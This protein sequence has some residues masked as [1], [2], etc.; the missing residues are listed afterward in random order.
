MWDRI[1]A[2][3][4]AVFRNTLPTA[5]AIAL[6][7]RL[8]WPLA[9]PPSQMS[10]STGAFT[11]P[12]SNALAARY[13]VEARRG[14]GQRTHSI[15][16][17][18]RLIYPAYHSLAW[19]AYETMGVRRLSTVVLAAL[20]GTATIAF[21]ALAV[22]RGPGD[23]AAIVVAVIGATNSWLVPNSRMFTPEGIA[24]FLLAIACF[25]AMSRR[26]MGWLA[27]GAIAAAAGTL[28]EISR[29]H[30]S[31]CALDLSP[32]TRRLEGCR[33][34]V[35]RSACSGFGMERRDLLSSPRRDHRMDWTKFRRRRGSF[36]PRIP[37][38]SRLADAVQSAQRF[39]DA[40]SHAD[41][42]AG[43]CLVCRAHAWL[44]RHVSAPDR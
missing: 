31:S 4:P 36:S 24:L 26:R 38:Q 10:W 33:E 9:D 39:L 41:R 42:V 27:A 6:L 12:P 19:I 18:E 37:F 23:Y 20:L 34:R 5:I 16:V 22:R 28:R 43:R 15:N 14:E 3:R 21:L 30:I 11:D 29:A 17:P 25:L 1:N 8:A 7:L 32:R 44:A 13:E 35:H 2:A 40:A